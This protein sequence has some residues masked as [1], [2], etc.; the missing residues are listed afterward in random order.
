MDP[1]SF[2]IKCTL[3][4]VVVLVEN[5]MQLIPDMLVTINL[6]S[7]SYRIGNTV[8]YFIENLW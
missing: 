8:F 5:L 2:K 7:Q 3:V 4:V 6:E 1:I